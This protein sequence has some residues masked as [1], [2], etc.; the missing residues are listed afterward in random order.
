VLLQVVSV[1]AARY[2]Y[3]VLRSRKAYLYTCSSALSTDIGIDICCDVRSVQTQRSQ[4][5]RRQSNQKLA[6]KLEEKSQPE[7]E[8][9][10]FLTKR[11]ILVLFL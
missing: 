8:P 3:N 7:K 1:F 4:A 6:V 11:T 9:V 2:L 5:A 10:W